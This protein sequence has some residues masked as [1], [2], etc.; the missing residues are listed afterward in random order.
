[1]FE[2]MKPRSFRPLYLASA[3]QLQALM[4]MVRPT[5]YHQPIEYEAYFSSLHVSFKCVS[6]YTISLLHFLFLFVKKVEVE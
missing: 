6:T 1:M 4:T 5:K 3:N 2:G